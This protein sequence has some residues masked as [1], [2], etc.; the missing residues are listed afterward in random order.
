MTVLDKTRLTGRLPSFSGFVAPAQLLR[1]RRSRFWHRVTQLREKPVSATSLPLSSADFQGESSMRTGFRAIGVTVACALF[2]AA[3]SG[4]ADVTPTPGTPT[5]TT[6]TVGGT[7]T[8]LAAGT[9]VTLQNNG[10]GNL[11]VNASGAFTFASSIASGAAYA[12]TV[13]TQPTG[14]TCSVAN[15]TGTATANVTNVAVTC[16]A[17]PATTYTIGGTVSGLAAGT[18]VVLQN[19]GVGNLTVNASGVFTFTSPIGSGAA[20]AVT[21]ATQPAGQT[22]SV[23]NGAGTATANVTAV[24]VTCAAL[25]PVTRT[26]GG[27]VSGLGA[28]TNVVLQNNGGGNLTVNANGSFTFASPIGN[29]AAYAVTVAT[30]PAGQTCSVANG[31]GLAAANVTNVAV[32]CAVLPPVTY[33]IGGSV[34]GLG[35]GKTVVL[36]NSAGGNVTANA[37]GAFT[38]AS[39]VGT[40]AAY[41]VT[42]QTQPAGQ[43]CSVA[44]GSGIASS[45][46]TNVAVTC[47]T[48]VTVGGTVSG[49]ASTATLVVQNNGANNLP[50]SANGSF[51]FTTS[52]AAGATYSVTVLTQP[53]VPGPGQTCVV[54]NGS[55]TTAS[56][57]V[58]NVAIA[59]TNTDQAAP[60]ISARTPLPTA[61]G[62]KVQG[63]V[64]TVTF[65]EAMNPTTVTALSSITLNGPSGPVSGTVAMSAGDTVATF[66]PASRLTFDADYTATVSTAVHDASDNALASASSWTFNS[67]KM[68][69]VGDLHV[70]ARM[71][72]G[73]VKCWGNNQTGELG[74]D[75]TTDLTTPAVAAVN[76]GVGRTAVSVVAGDYHT[77]ALLDDATVKCWGLNTSGD[78][79]QG[80]VSPSLGDEPGE[81]AALQP[82]NFG[83]GR[84]VLEVAVGQAFSCARLDDATVKC[85]GE[86]SRGQL[87]NGGVASLGGTPGDIAA[88]APLPL[89][90]GLT[91]VQLSLGHDHG[92]A[93]LTDGT[94]RFVECWG[95]NRWGQLGRGN[96]TTLGDNPG[97]VAAIS[98]IG[99]GTASQP[100]LVI[101]NGGHNCVQFADLSVK[102]WGLNTWGQT[103]LVAG[104]GVALNATETTRQ[105]SC[106]SFTPSFPNACIGDDTGEM[107]SNLQEVLPGILA[108]RLTVA[109]RHNCVLRSDTLVNCWGSNEQAQLGIEQASTLGST[110]AIL[111][112]EAGEMPP[113]AATLT[114]TSAIEELSA[115]GFQTCTVSTT[116]QINC[117]GDN[118][119]GQLGRGD[120]VTP[121]GDSAGEMGS[122]LIDINLGT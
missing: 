46:V 104:N 3:C 108:T 57:N 92:C 87:G 101:A 75:N 64:L 77:C 5:P 79:G 110:T 85:W 66:T 113:A 116:L 81:M 34:S 82:I 27:T 49:L 26:I 22:C 86:N 51:V 72:D 6:Y 119:H 106:A 115:G 53:T 19:N 84:K 94:D 97:E 32:T 58:T 10:G 40:G 35:V 60:T 30:Q 112:D 37:N 103:G 47:V 48:Q 12:V 100:K 83:A 93:M 7:V 33:T 61:I 44:N 121:I 50:V 9:T 111:G 114:K 117:W 73:R 80:S 31:S 20:Y 70:C 122:A 65:S 23:A 55:G 91:P 71:L 45:N 24:A 99:F 105:Q 43:I 18:T 41:A 28:G 63:G 25:P 36:Q 90:T 69:S 38:F 17:L 8:G 59:C 56:V 11:P 68:V 98:P 102:C 95:D 74:Y 4:G 14:Q 89:G 1:V 109:F 78:L 96:T 21:V 120:L 29:G 15:G 42:V 54:T 62:A 107:G 67:G 16:A 13:A 52:L 39:P 76:L 88:A 118:T 2:L